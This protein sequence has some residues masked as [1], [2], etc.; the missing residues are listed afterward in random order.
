MSMSH[1][2]AACINHVNV[3]L[4]FLHVNSLLLKYNE[5]HVIGGIRIL[6]MIR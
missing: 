4:G 2:F 3:L 5:Q 1:F 6:D